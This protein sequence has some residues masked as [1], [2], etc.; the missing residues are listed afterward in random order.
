M[1]HSR[2]YIYSWSSSLLYDVSLLAAGLKSHRQV[3]SNL[4]SII[5]IFGGKWYWFELS[6]QRCC[7]RGKYSADVQ[8][9]QLVGVVYIH[10]ACSSGLNLP[11]VPVRSGGQVC[12]TCR[13]YCWDPHRGD[14]VIVTACDPERGDENHN[15][16]VWWLCMG[17][18]VSLRRS[19]LLF[20]N[21]LLFIIHNTYHRV[22]H[23][24]EYSGLL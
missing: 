23:C 7:T 18:V 10:N 20:L 15:E 12:G 14:S 19:R 3:S 22:L 17:Q 5:F 21:S 1:C 11:C 16:E 9:W 2:K 6:N 13:Q 24:S 4:K 8:L